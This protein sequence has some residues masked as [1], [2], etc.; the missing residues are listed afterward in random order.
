MTDSNNL[1][2]RLQ[3]DHRKVGYKNIHKCAATVNGLLS[4]YLQSPYTSCKDVS[5]LFIG[6]KDVESSDTYYT[7]PYHKIT[8]FTTP[9]DED[10]I[11]T[12]FTTKQSSY[13]IDV[14]SDTHKEVQFKLMCVFPCQ[15]KELWYYMSKL[16]HDPTT[17]ELYVGTTRIPMRLLKDD[18]WFCY[19]PNLSFCLA[20]DLETDSIFSG[21][22]QAP[23][24]TEVKYIEKDQSF[25]GKEQAPTVT[26]VSIV[27][28]VSNTESVSN[29]TE[30]SSATETG[31]VT[32]KRKKPES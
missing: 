30:T 27:K 15:K 32:A 22:E 26:E 14:M 19:D 18:M 20:K 21:K 1:S 8:D 6:Y 13:P 29:V 4:A 12:I 23:P 28:E 10:L 3:T 7:S 2:I 24:A 17:I 11:Y 5:A 9:L 16:G 31:T 25:I